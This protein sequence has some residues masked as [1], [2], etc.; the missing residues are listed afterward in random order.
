MDALLSSVPKLA[1][2]LGSSPE[3]AHHAAVAITTTDLVSKS[4]ALEVECAALRP[5]LIS[6]VAWHDDED[7]MQ[8]SIGGHTVR[9]GG[10]AKGSGMIHPN[11]ATMLSVITTDAAVAPDVWR[12][13]IQRGA[14]N[15][16][17]QVL[18]KDVTG[19]YLFGIKSCCELVLCY[20][21]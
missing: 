8:V 14:I 19:W 3:H 1:G 2:S 10:I 16:F 21:R 20:C 15:S 18:A 13:I 7:L 4:A 17:N 9:M 11:M 6:A 5:L 12:G